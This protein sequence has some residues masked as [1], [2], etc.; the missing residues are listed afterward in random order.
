MPQYAVLI[1]AE[2]CAHALD[3]CEGDLAEPEGHGRDLATS[4]S[5]LA[6]WAFTPGALAT[7]NRAGGSPTGVCRCYHRSRRGLLFRRSR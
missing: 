1:Y 3:A 5:V 7:S 4:R 6:A 2:D